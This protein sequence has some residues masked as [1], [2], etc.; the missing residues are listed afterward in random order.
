MFAKDSDVT[1]KVLVVTFFDENF[2]Q[3]S[4]YN[5]V[6]WLIVISMRPL[7]LAK[8]LSKTRVDNYIMAN[9]IN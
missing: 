5:R 4:L 2:Y 8:N 6:S 3:V 7:I 1:N 9:Q